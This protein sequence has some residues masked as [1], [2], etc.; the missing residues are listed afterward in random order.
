MLAL[1][2]KIGATLITVTVLYVNGSLLIEKE[3]V[4]AISQFID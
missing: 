1:T 4:A 2:R 3:Q